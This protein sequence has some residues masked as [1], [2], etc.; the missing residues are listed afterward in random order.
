MVFVLNSVTSGGA[1][2][3]SSRGLLGR[4]LEIVVTS[5]ECDFRKRSRIAPAFNLLAELCEL[6]SPAAMLAVAHRRRCLFVVL[7]MFL[8]CLT[9]AFGKVHLRF[10]NVNYP[11]CTLCFNRIRNLKETL[12]LR[13]ASKSLVLTSTD[14]NCNIEHPS[15]YRLPIQDQQRRKIINF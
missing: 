7:S 9:L 8:Q 3:P 4:A 11:P 10:S 12:V 2:T 13:D 5:G 14:P 15:C 1:P 6:A